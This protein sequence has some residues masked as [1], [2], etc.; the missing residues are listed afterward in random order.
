[1]TLQSQTYADWFAVCATVVT[2]GMAGCAGSCAT[3]N[4]IS[5]NPNVGVA[6][7]AIAAVASVT[8]G[9]GGGEVPGPVDDGDAERAI[10]EA[11]IIQV[12][13]NK[14]YA[15][16]QYGGLS[17]IDVSVKD[18]LQL[19]GRYQSSGI[20]FEMYLRDGIVYAMFSSWEHYVFDEASSS[21]SRVQSSHIEAL[22]VHDP[23]AI[24]QV[25][26]FD[27][28]GDINDSRIVGDVLYAV[29]FEN[30]YCWGCQA[31]PNTTITSLA[32]ADPGKI[33]IVDQL[34][35]TDNNMEN[36]GWRRSVS[37]TPDRMYVAGIEWDGQSVGHSTIQVIDISDPTG[38]LVEGATVEATGQIQSRWQMDEYDGVLRVISQ[39]GL[40]S[41][42]A[43]PGVQ[44][45]SVLSAQN[46]TPLGFAE[47]KLPK[48]ESLRSVRFDGTRAYAITAERTDPLFTL[49]LS[50]PAAP[51][52]VGELEMPGW[53]YHM[54]PRGD[55]LLALG[56]DNQSPEG[57]LHVSLFDVSNLAAPQ[58]LERVA[59]GGKWSNLAEDQDRI[60]KAFSI[61]D[62]KGLLLVPY[63]AWN[64]S[65]SDSYGCGSFESGI[66]LIDFTT[67]TLTKRG[68]A[69]ALGQARRAFL[70]EDRLFAVSESE[71]RTFNIDDR[72]APAKLAD[73][74]LA[75]NVTQAVVAGVAGD[76]VV[77][78]SAD[79]WTKA[80]RLDIVAANNPA[81]AEP[82]GSLDL[83][84]LD[85]KNGQ[86]SCWASNFYGA[87]LLA[88]GQH[89]Y[90][91]W[92]SADWEKTNVTVIDI[93]DATQPKIAGQ[94][95][96]DVAFDLYGSSDW[97]GKTVALG[98]SVVQAGSTLVFE[99]FDFLGLYGGSYDPA[100]LRLAWLKVVDLSDPAD[101]KLAA[102]VELPEAAGHAALRI[103]GT[104]VLT[105]HWVPLPE[106]DTK[107]R[108]YLDRIDVA[109]PSS[110]ELLPPVNVPGS[111][112]S[113]DSA[114]GRLLTVDYQ[115]LVH[116]DITQDDCSGNYGYDVSFEPNDPDAYDGPGVCTTLRLAFKLVDVTGSSASLRAT[117][118]IAEDLHLSN[119]L[120]GDDRVFASVPGSFVKEGDGGYRTSSRVMV[121]GGMQDGALRVAFATPEL[122]HRLYDSAVAV[123]GKRLVMTSSLNAIG[124]LD[125]TN[126]DAITLENKGALVSHVS[127]VEIVGDHALCSMRQYGLQVVDLGE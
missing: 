45:F 109:N 29:S 51:K 1:M 12:K 46:V 20:P 66:Q 70:H 97:L 100:S 14:L 13:D 5:D 64:Y 122:D 27:L 22:D 85:A 90:L 69:P 4:F 94:L 124:V 126:L 54:E 44:T 102:S 82:S 111:L 18:H 75:N 30:G 101:P 16:S 67:D 10:A 118:P 78:L 76:Q 110:P 115:R 91:L 63:S 47:L 121:V 26:S 49:D 39:P 119:V 58:M 42:S 6:Q 21:Y 24:A 36:Y 62:D 98:A 93:S 55:R 17:I 50:D 32:V 40:W 34:T 116:K 84:S 2:I 38:L 3:G 19:L 60:H 79:W 11:D 99:K 96:V 74:P 48:P 120:V 52:Q 123:D 92:P 68:V 87:K 117:S 23:A 80:S 9:S 103:E 95:A 35:F 88:N 72:S 112:V 89:V 86:E 41:T 65:Q 31:S 57:S 15:L 114:T 56:F 83:S 77:R 37:V 59:F 125:A 106:D 28:P 7:A 107:V 73:L 113:F 43:V 104:T 108:F 71:V 81:S 33:G 25:G 127:D 61:L 53:V 8:A 105:S